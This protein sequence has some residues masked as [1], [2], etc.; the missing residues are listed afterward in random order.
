M[1][2]SAHAVRY[3]DNVFVK[4]LID[5]G[6]EGFSACGINVVALDIDNYARTFEF[7]LRVV[8]TPYAGIV[9]FSTVLAAK[10]KVQPGEEPYTV[11]TPTPIKFWIA[12]DTD[13][14][15]LS[16]E[17]YVKSQKEGIA[18]AILAADE[19]LIAIANI[20]GGKRMQFAITYPGADKNSTEDILSFAA[21]IQEKEIDGLQACLKD[22][23]RRSQSNR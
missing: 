23:L 16:P 4:S 18:L 10:G 15:R 20:A 21:P 12:V 9:D 17:R 14:K 22:I 6:D 3:L 5:R 7:N 8:P 19:T 2:P 13:P 11:V 1:M